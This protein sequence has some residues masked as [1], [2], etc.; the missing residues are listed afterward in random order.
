MGLNESVV[1]LSTGWRF[2]RYAPG[3]ADADYDEHD[4][5]VVSVPHTVA[6]LGWRDWDPESWEGRWIYRQHFDA[7]PQDGRT[8]VDFGAAM[9]HAMPSLN[10]TPLDDHLGGYLPFSREITGLLRPH[11]NLL[12]VVL[13]SSFNLNVPPSRPAPHPATSVDY[14]QPGGLYRP[15][16]LRTVP[17]SFVAD[18]FAKP[19]DV[20]DPG[21][22]R[23]DLECTLDVG[24]AGGQQAA[25]EVVL[26]DASGRRIASTD[27]ELTLQ[28][29]GMIT[30]T[31]VLDR[32]PDI[33]LWDVDDPRLYAVTATLS[34]A[35]TPVHS[36]SVRTGFR[37]ARFELDGFYLNG[38]RLQLF[39]ANRHQ[40]YPYA[41]AAMPDR[42]QRKDAEILRRDL[43]CNMVRC[44]HYPQ[45]EP[46]FD[47]CDELGL[48]AWE[49]APG[50][51]YLGDDAWKRH[52]QRDVG[53][54]VRRDRNHPSIIIWGAR[55]NETGDDNTLYTRTRD[56]THD[57]DGSRPTA[58]AMAGRINTPD[59]VHEV[60]SEDDYSSS[61]G[62]DG[63]R[64]PRFEPPRAD[65]PY[66]ISETVGTLSGPE[67]YYRRFG[68]QTEQQGQALAYARVH[69]LAA[70][71]PHFC[72]VLAWSGFDYESGTGN[73]DHAV[74][75][76]G[77]VDLFRIPKPG[78]AFYQA[79]RDPG[80][81]PLIAPAFYWDF[82]PGSPVTDLDTAMICSNLDRLEL[83]VGDD[84]LATAWPDIKTYPNLA[85]PPS[86]VDLRTVDGSSRPELR[87]DGYLADD[88]VLSR[89]FSSDPAG[90]V[91]ALRADD[92][93][94]IADGIDATRIEFRALDRYGAPRPY[95]QGD[96]VLEIDGPVDLIGENP[97]PFGAAGAAGAVWIRTR[98]GS[99]GSVRIRAEHPT[100]GVAETSVLVADQTQASGRDA[101][102]VRSGAATE[103]RS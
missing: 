75:C 91:L 21:R 58:G 50:W 22:R 63:R 92:A 85:Y 76:T 32:L 66:L 49:E 84:H 47:A 28:H 70:A 59:Y 45:A 94:L 88:L 69:Q 55:L 25:V 78:A 38:R 42:V 24:A 10:G 19:V 89:R 48:M 68:S 27:I 98:E 36:R 60:F 20:L 83:F 74:K 44:S 90:D 61:I 23:V 46:F 2:G 73:V 87:I 57:L 41:G 31:G 71:D 103:P 12:A 53:E 35:G 62:P 86:F 96:L 14:W 56:L 3:R 64:Q 17:V 52:A 100:L 67:L 82:G 77:L 54:M 37:E 80:S 15:V 26:A 34:I 4:L 29:T 16:R 99:T 18:L 9:T 30:I 101:G 13:D 95:V 1:N 93:E 72:G 11:D 6:D 102:T 97:F 40:L 51:G 33:A 5:A 7:P 81:G 8:F 43:N 65:L 39:G 79:Q